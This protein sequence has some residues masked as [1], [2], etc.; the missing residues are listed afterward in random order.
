M[1]KKTSL[2]WYLFAPMVEVDP[3]RLP[4]LKTVIKDVEENELITISLIL[5]LMWVIDLYLD[6]KLNI[7]T[8]IVT[9]AFSGAISLIVIINSIFN[10]KNNQKNIK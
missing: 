6:G 8:F 4:L 2:W 7:G 9:L 1:E 10:Y 5:V 3:E